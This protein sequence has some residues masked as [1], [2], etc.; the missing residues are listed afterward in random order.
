MGEAIN[1]VNN[2]KVDN[3]YTANSIHYEVGQE[4]RKSI[5]RLGGTMQ[6]EL[7]TPNSSLKELEKN[8]KKMNNQGLFIFILLVNSNA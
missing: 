7:P 6:E 1:L 5:E 2:Y 8:I 3:E 4:V